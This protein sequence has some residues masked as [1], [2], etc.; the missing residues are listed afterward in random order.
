MSTR[1]RAK[2]LISHIQN[3]AAKL[4]SLK[5]KSANP[6]ANAEPKKCEKA[7]SELNKLIREGSGEVIPK[8]RAEHS[9]YIS[10]AQELD[11]SAHELSNE[12]AKRAIAQSA[13]EMRLQA[14]KH[15]Q[16]IRNLEK[17][18]NS[19]RSSLQRFKASTTSVRCESAKPD[20]TNGTSAGAEKGSSDLES[21]IDESGSSSGGWF[22]P[23]F[24]YNLP[25]FPQ[26]L[27]PSPLNIYPS[28]SYFDG[29]MASEYY[30]NSTLN[31]RSGIHPS[32]MP[33]EPTSYA[34]YGQYTGIQG[35]FL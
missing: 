7:V 29:M 21:I 34:N 14:H 20:T 1:E 13:R 31:R 4:D 5:S 23:G 17:A 28:P 30:Y 19:A 15:K 26:Y 22:Y 11:D 33:Y 24:H 12:R 2:R 32:L 3:S 16:T 10:N 6:E 9:E 25:L 27:Y 35:F 18:V 8:L